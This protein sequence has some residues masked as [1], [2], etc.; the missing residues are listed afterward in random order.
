MNAVSNAVQNT[1]NGK[2]LGEIV[3]EPAKE[4]LKKSYAAISSAYDIVIRQGGYDDTKAKLKGLENDI[5]EKVYDILKISMEHCEGKLPMVKAYFAMLC[6]KSEE[7]FLSKYIKANKEETTIAKAIPLWP[8]YKSSLLK[9]LDY[10]MSPAVVID[11]TDAPRWPTAAK[12]RTEVQKREKEEKGGNASTP[13]QRNTAK[14]VTNTVS[15]VAKNWSDALAGAMNVLC[16]ALNRLDHI[17]QDRF[18]SAVLAL[19]TQ[20]TAFAD[21]RKVAVAET[22]PAQEPAPSAPPIPVE[23]DEISSEAK[24]ALQN[25]LTK[26]EPKVEAPKGRGKQRAA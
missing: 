20:V 24:A 19:G 5:G 10:Q 13:D 25:A 6:K 15:L 14:Q 11:D 7:Y 26:P 17:D 2:T 4:D 16:T 21:Q 3:N 8:A 9:G 22:A 12:F 23:N 18:A 1:L